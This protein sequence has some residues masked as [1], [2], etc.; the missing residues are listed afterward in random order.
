[1]PQQIRGLNEVLQ[2]PI[3]S[4]AVGLLLYARENTAAP[5]RLEGIGGGVKGAWQRVRGWVRGNY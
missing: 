2:S 3:Y 1:L 4:T 5:M